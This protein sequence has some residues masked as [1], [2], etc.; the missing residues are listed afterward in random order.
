[1]SQQ[2]RNELGKFSSKSDENRQVRSIRLTDATW[3]ALGEVANKRSI[4]RADL[5]EGWFVDGSFSLDNI[6]KNL[7]LEINNLKASSVY[8]PESVLDNLNKIANERSITREE[9]IINLLAN[10]VSHNLRIEVVKHTQL[11]LLPEPKNKSNI[12]VGPLN[13]A[14][15][16]KRLGVDAS[17]LKRQMAKG[18]DKFLIYSASKDPDGLGWKY[19]QSEK[20]YYPVFN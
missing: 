2:G 9:L 11:D 6:I 8:L 14:N 12:N 7:E 3:N 18:E 20:L 15:L 10:Y 17:N 19:S 5:I 1:M 13:N 16:A 4:T